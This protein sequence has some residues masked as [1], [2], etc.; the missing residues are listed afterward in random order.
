[1]PRPV[2]LEHQLAEVDREIK[3]RQRVYARWVQ[4]GKMK[5]DV[6]SEQRERLE[7]VRD[8]LLGLLADREAKVP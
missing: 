4:T 3:V 5:P 1:M 8:T 7:A 2:P 6:A